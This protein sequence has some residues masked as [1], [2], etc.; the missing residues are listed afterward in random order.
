MA[1]PSTP[2]SPTFASHQFSPYDVSQSNLPSRKEL[3]VRFLH[4]PLRILRPATQPAGIWITLH[5]PTSFIQ[6]AITNPSTKILLLLVFLPF[7]R[8]SWHPLPPF[9]TDHDFL[10]RLKYVLRPIPRLSRL[11]PANP[12]LSGRLASMIHIHRHRDRWFRIVLIQIVSGKK[13]ETSRCHS[14]R[15]ATSLRKSCS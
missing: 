1:S 5:R 9:P 11:P 15:L 6:S 2:P 7:P 8:M 4:S 13:S 10:I 14:L 12:Y 3:P